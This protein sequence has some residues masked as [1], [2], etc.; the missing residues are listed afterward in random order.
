MMSAMTSRVMSSCVGPSPPQ[1]MTASLRS[2][3]CVMT[4]LMRSQLSP[5]FVWKWESM[6]TSASCSPIHDE[7]VS[8]I[9]PSSNSVPTATTSQRMQNLPMAQ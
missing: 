1:T 2:S 9:W 5:T 7:L 8:T 3:A 4:D 6:P